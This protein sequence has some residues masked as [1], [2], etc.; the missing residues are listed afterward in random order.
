MKIAHHFNILF[1]INFKN[2]V[3]KINFKN[4]VNKINFRIKVNKINFRIKIE[5]YI[6]HVIMSQY[7]IGFLPENKAGI[8]KVLNSFN[9]SIIT[10]NDTDLYF[11]MTRPIIVP[12]AIYPPNVLQLLLFKTYFN[13]SER[14]SNLVRKYESFSKERGIDLKINVATAEFIFTSPYVRDKYSIF[15]VKVTPAY[16]MENVHRIMLFI[17]NVTNIC[18]YRLK[19]IKYLHSF[20]NNINNYNDFECFTFPTRNSKYSIMVYVNLSNDFI[21]SHCNNILRYMFNKL[22]DFI[23]NKAD[24]TYYDSTFIHDTEGEENLRIDVSE[25]NL[26]GEYV[27]NYDGHGPMC[28]WVEIDEIENYLDCAYTH[29]NN[30]EIGFDPIE[31]TNTLIVSDECP[32]F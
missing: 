10:V 2:K 32:S 13:R 20:Y 18:M 17:F 6:N 15:T 11:T 31:E 8:I 1:F 9:A 27:Y 4:K 21:E 22:P 25:Y 3:N 26:N 16:D 5:I 12:F 23:K 30:E 7:H 28:E 14:I 19:V 29:Y 24:D